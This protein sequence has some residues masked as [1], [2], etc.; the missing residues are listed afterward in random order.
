[1]NEGLSC[2]WCERFFRPRKSGGK[3]QRFCRPSCR[4]AFHAAARAWALDA[5][6]IGRLTIA[7]LRKGAPGDARVAS[8]GR[9]GATQLA[10]RGAFFLELETLPPYFTEL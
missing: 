7:D 9:G 1:M 3:G 8:S 10:D 2:V 5:L 6:A 4:R